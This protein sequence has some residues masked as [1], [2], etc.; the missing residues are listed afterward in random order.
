MWLV[1]N[2]KIVKADFEGETLIGCGKGDDDA[3]LMAELGYDAFDSGEDA[4]ADPNAGTGG[5]VGVGAQGQPF[6]QAGTD[7]FEFLAADHVA[8]FI[9]EDAQDTGNGNDG[10]LVLGRETGKGVS[11]KERALGDY[12]AVGPFDTLGVE[13]EIVLDGTDDEV[14]GN[15]L[16]MIRDDV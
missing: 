10:E 16:F 8:L 9:A 12:G 13:R 7:F 6:G 11:R 5:D 2:F 3:A 14:L 4:C 15:S 1:E